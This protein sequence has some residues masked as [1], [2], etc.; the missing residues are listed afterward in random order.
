MT[1]VVP[2]IIHT[3]YLGMLEHL[4][5][6]VTSFLDRHSRIGKSDQLRAM[7]LPYPGFA[8]FNKPYSQVTQWTGQELKTLRHVIVPVFMATLL[9]PSG[10]LEDYLLRIP[11]V[12]QEPCAFSPYGSVPVPY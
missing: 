8:R 5:D 6:W 7:I 1:I 4:T 12:C 11:A 3:V 2:D 9:N 10:E